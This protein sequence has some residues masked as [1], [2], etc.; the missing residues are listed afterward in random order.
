MHAR[1]AENVAVVGKPGRPATKSSPNNTVCCRADHFPPRA[2]FKETPTKGL[3]ETICY[4]RFSCSNSSWMMLSSRG[5]L[6]LA[7]PKKI[8][9]WPT[10]CTCSNKEL[11]RRSKTLYSHKIDVKSVADGVHQSVK[12][13][14]HQFDISR[15]RSQWPA[16]I[17]TF[18]ACHAISV[19]WV[20]VS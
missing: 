3:T 5:S 19:R 9:E 20:R 12:N 2:W 17:T 15:L 11:Q 4:V 8:T 13:I 16:S 1:T 10:V 18:A 6:T 7:T 14:L